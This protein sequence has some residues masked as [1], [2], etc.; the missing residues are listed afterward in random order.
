MQRV[1]GSASSGSHHPGREL[2]AR[3]VRLFTGEPRTNRPAIHWTEMKPVDFEGE[4]TSLRESDL[5]RMR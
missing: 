1:I 3:V 5:A 2:L 4:D